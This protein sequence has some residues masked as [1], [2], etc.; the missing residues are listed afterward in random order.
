M[1]RRAPPGHPWVIAH[2]GWSGR[3][4]ENTLPAIRA[5]IGLGVDLVE[6]DVQ[7]TRDGKL[8]VFHDYRL[9]RIL[10]QHRRV[11]DVRRRELKGVPSL[12]QALHVC[13]GKVRLLIE[14]KGASGAKV[15]RE[16]ARQHMER[17]VIVFSIREVRTREL[18]RENPRIVVFALGLSRLRFQCSGFTVQGWGDSRRLVTSRAVV[19]RYHRRGLKLLVWTVNRVEDMQ[20]LMRWGVDG[21][22]TNH[23]DRALALRSISRR[24]PADSRSPRPGG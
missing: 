13:R 1:S 21:L 24:A 6:I 20:R 17:Q 5:A 22:I 8:V 15:A 2:R 19:E 14:I 9:D 11:R 10:G 4:T 23:P 12:A 3:Y 7:E 16:I 18:H